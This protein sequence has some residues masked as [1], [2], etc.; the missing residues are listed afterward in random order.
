VR[1]IKV[2]TA[3][4]LL[5][6]RQVVPVRGFSPVSV[7]AVGDALDKT[8]E[9]FYNGVQADEFMVQS[10]NRLLIRV[11]D[12]QLGRPL[13]SVVAYSSVPTTFG[14]AA[15]AFKV[16][17]PVRSVSGVERMVQS[18]LLALLTTPGSDI[19]SKSSG[20]GLSSLIG[21]SSVT[22][23]SA[24][25]SDIALAI[26]RTKSEILREQAKFPNMPLEERLM[27]A[28]LD[29]VSFDKESSAMYA[30]ISLQNMLGQGAEVS[31][32]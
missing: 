11:P 9:V 7:L 29:S 5:P 6:I 27:A 17:T 28:A 3:R 14:N 31:L 22:T 15:L 1:D 32:G 30:K 21:K 2:I 12:A 18:F 26:E 10:S 8:S 13:T 23:G 20:G 24:V 16:H 25:S 4:A 19:F